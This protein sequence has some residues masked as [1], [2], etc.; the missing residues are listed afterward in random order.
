MEYKYEGNSLKPG[1][2]KITNILSKKNY[3]GSAK[4]FKER[5][6]RHASSLRHGRHGNE[7]LQNSFSKYHLETGDE[8]FMEFTILEIMEGS[9]K[10]ERLIREEYWIRKFLVEGLALYNKQ[11]EPTKEPKIVKHIETMNRKGKNYEE[12]FGSDLAKSM[13]EKQSRSHKIYYDSNPKAMNSMRERMT[14]ESNPF[15]GKKHTDETKK[16]ISEL[17]KGKSLEERCGKETAAR[18]RQEMSEATLKYFE[19]DPMK[20]EILGNLTRGRT[21]E[22]IY[23][24]EKAENIKKQ[25]SKNIAKTYTGFTLVDPSGNIYT[26]IVNLSFFCIQHALQSRLLSKLLKGKTKSHR[27]WWLADSEQV[28][29]PKTKICSQ[30]KEEK[31]IS[32]FGNKS[33]V[34]DGKRAHCKA[35]QRK[36]KK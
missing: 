35:C 32:L 33:G 19:K 9:T 6:T 5:W 4:R 13:R 11:L 23:G 26:K 31:S 7:H 34:K 12:I 25:R 8:S 14:G 18:R 20:K 22:E 36:Y 27:G 1:I 28:L 10:E 15:F 2:Y 3:I 30:C 21:L 29:D 17:Q 16:K 24:V